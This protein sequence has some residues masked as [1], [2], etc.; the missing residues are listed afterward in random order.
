MSTVGWVDS[1]RL[2]AVARE[3]GRPALG[4]GW[5]KAEV[6]KAASNQGFKRQDVMCMHFDPS[7]L[8]ALYLL[9]Y[10]LS[11]ALG[12]ILFVHSLLMVAVASP[13]PLALGTPTSRLPSSR[14]QSLS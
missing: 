1:D 4:V 9:P 12:R 8:K 6:M 5:V 14:P 10:F 7:P 3:Q 13:L 2:G 11:S